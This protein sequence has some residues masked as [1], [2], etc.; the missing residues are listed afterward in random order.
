MERGTF[1]TANFPP[2]DVKLPEWMSNTINNLRYR[3]ITA[4]LIIGSVGVKHAE[5]TSE[6]TKSSFGKSRWMKACRREKAVRDVGTREYA[7]PLTGRDKPSKRHCR[8]D[9]DEQA[10]RVI[11]HI[12]FRQFYAYG[13]K[14]GCED[15]THDLSREDVRYVRPRTRIENTQGM[16][17]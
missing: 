6:D 1:F 12:P 2:F 16:R 10:L 3:P 5:M 17:S 14:A 13:K 4:A 11:R 15:D 8:H 7:G 9:H